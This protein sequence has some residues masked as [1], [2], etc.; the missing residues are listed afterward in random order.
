[1]SL[2]LKETLITYISH[3]QVGILYKSYLVQNLVQVITCRAELYKLQLVQNL[4]QILYKLLQQY[5]SLMCAN[6]FFILTFQITV[7]FNIGIPFKETV[8]M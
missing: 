8:E 3:V 7:G 4:F 2:S 1:M 6:M 5:S